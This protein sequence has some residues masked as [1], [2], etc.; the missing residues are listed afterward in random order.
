MIEILGWSPTLAVL[1]SFFFKDMLNLRLANSTGAVLWLVYAFLKNDYPLIAV[2]GAILFV[3]G[4]WFI[5][6]YKL[7]KS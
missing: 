4:Y 3:H 1:L 2:N 7:W 5:S 6:N